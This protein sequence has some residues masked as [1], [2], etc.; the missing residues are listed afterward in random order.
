MGP[1]TDINGMVRLIGAHIRGEVNL[2]SATLVNYSGPALC[3]DSLRVDGNMF[4]CDD[5]HA[6]GKSTA[7]AIR[8]VGAHITGQLDLSSATVTNDSGPAINADGLQVDRNMLLED[9]LANGSSPPCM[10]T[11]KGAHIRGKLD[12]T[13]ATL[14]SKFDSAGQAKTADPADPND[15]PSNCLL[16]DFEH[17]TV[18]H[19]LYLSAGLICRTLTYD[20]FTLR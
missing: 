8:L 20:A 15:S 17:A 14:D 18:E 16:I 10:I 5:F 12:L 7:G 6:I 9:I 19:G 11:F 2:T 3:A 13:D 1:S 4:L